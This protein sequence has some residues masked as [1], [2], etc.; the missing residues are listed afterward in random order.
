MGYSGFNCPK[1]PWAFRYLQI[2]TD[3]VRLLWSLNILKRIKLQY[4]AFLIQ[5]DEK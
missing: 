2:A 1:I 3:L 4:A 5:I